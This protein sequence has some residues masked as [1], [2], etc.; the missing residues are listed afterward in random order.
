MRE[1][2]FKISREEIERIKEAARALPKYQKQQ[3]SRQEAIE[4]LEPTLTEME[5][6]LELP[7]SAI[8]QFLADQGLPMSASTLQGYRRK[9]GEKKTCD[10]K[11][12]AAKRT[13]HTV[14]I[15]AHP[16]EAQA[17][18]L[19]EAAQDTV[20][21]ASEFDTIEVA[22]SDPVATV[23]DASMPPEP[24]IEPEPSVPPVVKPDGTPDMPLDETDADAQLL[25]SFSQKF[26]E[27]QL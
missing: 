19:S 13:K 26:E 21:A 15:I 17:Q 23:I 4:A 25:K 27:W 11:V 22:G 10:P 3:L 9:T 16:D 14:A 12:K 1:T 6:D 24:A 7:L 20:E 2:R 8:L 18:P 5:R